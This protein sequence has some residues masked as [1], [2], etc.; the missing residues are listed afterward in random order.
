M[1]FETIIAIAV[2]MLVLVFIWGILK[3][4]VKIFFYAGIIILLIFA[5]YSSSIY[6]DFTGLNDN[7]GTSEK[8]VILVDNNKAIAGLLLGK[9]KGTLT[10]AELGRYSSYLQDKNYDEILGN[11]YKLIILNS[12]I[13]IDLGNKIEVGG[14]IIKSEDAL[15]NL[16][17]E[18]SEEKSALFGAIVEDNVL[19]SKN[20]LFFFSELRKGNI[21]VYPETAAFKTMEFIPLSWI[22]DAGKKMFEK[23]KE[24]AEN[25]V[26]EESE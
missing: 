8:K 1:A 10:S 15:S 23:T 4:T 22:K 5:A 21:K 12:G 11:S 7:L 24:T 17:S 9:D 16:K 25:F 13:I 26:A 3:R 2:F 6:K 18:D 19:G 14:S 20:P